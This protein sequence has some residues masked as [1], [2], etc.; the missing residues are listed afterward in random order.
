MLKPNAKWRLALVV[1]LVTLGA[2]VSIGLRWM[3]IDND[4]REVMRSLR[5]IHRSVRRTGISGTQQHAIIDG[6]I[7]NQLATIQSACQLRDVFYKCERRRP[8]YVYFLAQTLVLFR[9]AE[10]QDDNSAR[11][12]VDLLAD[13]AL[14]W[15]GESSLNIYEALVRCGQPCVPYLSSYSGTNKKLALEAIAEIRAASTRPE[16]DSSIGQQPENYEKES[17][18]TE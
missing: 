14:A 17:G 3:A 10:M 18:E 16:Q 4:V 1:G 7:E 2:I 9:L 13:D 12:L 8:G 5:E 6:R 11:I 15:D